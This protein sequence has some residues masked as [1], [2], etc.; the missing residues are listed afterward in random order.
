MPDAP[1]P[2][3][4]GEARNEELRAE[5]E[6]LAPGERPKIIAVSAAITLVL[7][8]VNGVLA[9]TGYE[10]DGA[11]TTQSAIIFA[12][13]MLA[14]TVGL[15]QVQYWAAVGFQV[16]LGL[17]AVSAGLGLLVSSNLR[18]LVLCVVLLVASGTLFWFLIR[19]MGRM[20][21]PRR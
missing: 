11:N 14:L 17:T 18:A 5:L 6:P 15:W 4:R 7:A 9:A 21:A 19:A 10:V 1:P 12:A 13:I 20:Q 8:V 2:R 16:V 3:L